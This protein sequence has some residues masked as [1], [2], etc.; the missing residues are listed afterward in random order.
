MICTKQDEFLEEK[1]IWIAYL[2]D[3]T[4]VYQDDDRPKEAE[5]NAWLR[6]KYHLLHNSSPIT[7]SRLFLRFRSHIVELPPNANGYYFSK[8][9][10]GSTGKMASMYI[11]GA[12]YKD[13]DEIDCIWFKIPELEPAMRTIRYLSKS[14]EEF[15]IINEK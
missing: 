1:V 4:I 6:L 7:L 15:V 5:P 9:G 8:G 10:I 14:P 2:S 13:V 3:G 12:I 11:C